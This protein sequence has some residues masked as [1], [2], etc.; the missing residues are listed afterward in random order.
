MKN[1]KT[2]EQI[3]HDNFVKN[4]EQCWNCGNNIDPD[5]SYCEECGTSR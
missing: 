5:C 2:I 1:S 3:D 4:T